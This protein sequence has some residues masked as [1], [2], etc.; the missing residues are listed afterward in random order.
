MCVCVG[1]GVPEV[2][3]PE[4]FLSSDSAHM[5][6]TLKAEFNFFTTSLA[7]IEQSSSICMQARAIKISDASMNS[8]E[9][10]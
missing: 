10:C 1:G 8:Q 4:Y 6:C 3:V 9:R 2:E 5:D 7:V